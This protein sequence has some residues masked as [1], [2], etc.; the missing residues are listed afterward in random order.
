[1]LVG[2]GALEFALSQGFKKKTFLLQNRKRMERM[3]KNKS[4]QT[5]SK[6]RK[7]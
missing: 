1:M 4:V 7:S 6:Y 5:D 3:A 2:D